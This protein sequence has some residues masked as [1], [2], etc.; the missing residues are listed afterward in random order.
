MYSD[1]ERNYQNRPVLAPGETFLW[2]GKPQKKGFIATKSLSLLPIAVIWL[3]LDIS[4]IG[5][6]MGNGANG[7]FIPFFAL[8]LMPVWIWLFNVLTAGKRW[9]NTTYYVTNRR[10]IFQSGVIAPNETVLYYKD[11]QNVNMRIGILDKIFHTGDIL[12]DCGAR[13]SKGNVIYLSFEDLAEPRSVFQ[14]IQKIILDIQTD[15]EFP[16]AYRPANNPGY[17]TDYNP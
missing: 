4:F 5:G 6:A 2:E 15:I 14:R 17:N 3:A 11:I 9:K 12:F 10:I 7:I 16:N 13:N 1:Y 8:H